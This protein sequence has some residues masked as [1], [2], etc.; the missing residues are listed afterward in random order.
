MIK[1]NGLNDKEKK[2][3]E[4]NGLNIFNKNYYICA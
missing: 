4:Y 3:N 1:Q 2:H